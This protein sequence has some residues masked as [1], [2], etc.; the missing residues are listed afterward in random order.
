MVV[1]RQNIV[2]LAESHEWKE[3][4]RVCGSGTEERV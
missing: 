2:A 1:S 3:V 4:A